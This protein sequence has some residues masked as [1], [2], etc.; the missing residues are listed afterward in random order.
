M[1]LGRRLEGFRH[2][3]YAE[4]PGYEV[5]LTPYTKEHENEL[6]IDDACD[7]LL[8]LGPYCYTCIR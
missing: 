2:T 3:Q 4:R 7:W 6:I 5:G 8:T 1:A